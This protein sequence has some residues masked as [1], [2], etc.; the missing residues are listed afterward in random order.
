MEEQFPSSVLEMR[1][2]GIEVV[3]VVVVVEVVEVEFEF[4]E[5]DGC[6]QK[7]DFSHQLQLSHLGEMRNAVL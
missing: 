4:V 6:Y 2:L 7:F 1:L 3:V 5:I